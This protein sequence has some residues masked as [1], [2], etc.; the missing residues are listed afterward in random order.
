MIEITVGV[1]MH[2]N[3]RDFQSFFNYYLK[4]YYQGAIDCSCVLTFKL[5]L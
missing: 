3:Q 4:K 1:F 2:F 5:L